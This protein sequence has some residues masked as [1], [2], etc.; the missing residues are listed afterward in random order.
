MEGKTLEEVRPEWQD[1]PLDFMFDLL[2]EE[3]GKVGFV[4]PDVFQQGDKYLRMVMRYPN[5]CIEGDSSALATSGPVSH[6]HPHPRN[7]GW[8]PR[9][10]GKYCRNERVLT[11]NEAIRKMT[12]LPA[13]RYGIKDRGVISEGMIADIMI[14]DPKKV[15]DLATYLNPKQ[16]PIGIPYVIVNGELVIN[17][18]EHTGKLPGKVLKHKRK[19]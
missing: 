16:Y 1:D 3:E 11:Y 17:K 10:L 2:I 9:A 12:S 13:L 14:F 7:Y 15:I 6:G 19:V 4:L 18:G 8:V 5:M